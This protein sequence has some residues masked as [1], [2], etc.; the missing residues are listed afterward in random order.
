MNIAMSQP[1][2][3]DGETHVVEFL[4]PLLP[5]LGVAFLDSLLSESLQL[6]VGLYNFSIHFALISSVHLGDGVLSI[7]FMPLGVSANSR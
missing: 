1:V 5:L 3:E 4:F 7:S 2:L 6:D